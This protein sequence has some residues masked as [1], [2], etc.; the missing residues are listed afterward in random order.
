[1]FWKCHNIKN[2]EDE[3]ECVFFTAPFSSQ[4]VNK[5]FF[6]A[7]IRLLGKLIFNLEKLTEM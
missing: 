4:S 6:K 7:F 2:L 3:A 5:V 1:M